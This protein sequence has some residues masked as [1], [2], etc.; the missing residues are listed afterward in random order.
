MH[1]LDCSGVINHVAGNVLASA[2]RA[3]EISMG[4]INQSR[5][6]FY[7]QSGSRRRLPELRERNLFEG[8]NAARSAL[9]ADSRGSGRRPSTTLCEFK[10]G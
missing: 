5:L 1:V 10:K 4:D 2:W 7:D 6:A 3:G 9:Q 8:G